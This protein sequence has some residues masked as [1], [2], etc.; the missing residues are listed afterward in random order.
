MKLKS[1]L[2]M[3]GVC[4]LA[5]CGGSSAGATPPAPPT[6]VPAGPGASTVTAGGRPN[7]W[8][9][10]WADEFDTDGLPAA[11]KWDYDTSRNKDGWFNN[12][13]EYY[14]RARLE[15][16]RVV[17]GKLIIAARKESLSSAADFGGQ[18]YTSGRL[19]TRGKASWTYGFFE[20]R[21][22]LPCG[23][24]TW[25]AIWMLGTGG[26]WPDDG[27]I[28]IMEHLGKNKG[29]VMGTVHTGAYNWTLG[30]QKSGSTVL[31]D[32]CDTFHNYQLTW[33]SDHIAVG[34][35]DKNYFQF[36]NPKDG[37]KRKWPFTNPQFLLINLAIGGDLG[38]PVDDA[39][40]PVQMEVEYVRVYQP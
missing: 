24:G 37:D 20:V 17:N 9:L 11:D 14:P 18:A 40:L 13:L 12:E 22:K 34:V 4:T 6:I 3:A 35:D 30:T 31:G 2:L 7:G 1:Q 38:G 10:V 5:G 33:D 27:E 8:K 26:A 28:D 29:Q 25:P 36:I 23:L 39:I 21:A 19:L 32:A 16:T 15:N